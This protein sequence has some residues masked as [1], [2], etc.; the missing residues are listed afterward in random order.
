MRWPSGRRTPRALA[1]EVAFEA[2]ADR[3][4]QQH[5]GPPGPRTTLII[6]G[7]R[8]PRLEIGQ[9]EVTAALTYS[10][11]TSSGK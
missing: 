10:S 9:A 5:A 4:V 1:I 2:V 7:L 6:A 8:R 11:I 3:L